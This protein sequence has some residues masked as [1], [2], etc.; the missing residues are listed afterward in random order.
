MR[1]LALL[2]FLVSD[3]FSQ[4]SP[5]P[6]APNSDG[7]GPTFTS[8]NVTLSYQGSYSSIRKVDFR[9]FMF[10]IFDQAG[11]PAGSLSFKNGHYKRDETNAHFSMDLGSIYYLTLGIRQKRRENAS[12]LIRSELAGVMRRRQIANEL[13]FFAAFSSAR[14]P[15]RMPVMP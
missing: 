6:Y 1:Q 5:V 15:A 13:Y 10:P 7:P 11:K 4:K 14:A 2:F 9:N 12:S 3:T 8:E